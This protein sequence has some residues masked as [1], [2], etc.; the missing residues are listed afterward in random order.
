MFESARAQQLSDELRTL[1]RRV[2]KVTIDEL[3][4]YQQVGGT[5][6]ASPDSIAIA[7]AKMQILFLTNT[8][9]TMG[10]IL[11]EILVD[12]AEEREMGIS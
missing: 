12:A 3:D 6:P 11:L 7:A 1:L 8:V 5:S 9:A 10:T 2:E 4:L